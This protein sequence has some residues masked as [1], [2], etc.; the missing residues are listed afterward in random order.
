M[1]AAKEREEQGRRRINERRGEGQGKRKG[2]GGGEN[3]WEK[4]KGQQEKR[5]GEEKTE[6]QLTSGRVY[7]GPMTRVCQHCQALRFPSELFNC[8]HNGKV[9]LPPLGDYPS[10]LKD[11]FTGSNILQ[12]PGRHEAV[13]Q[14]LLLCFNYLWLHYTLGATVWL[15][16]ASN[17]K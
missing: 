8:C 9:S 14:C 10:P 2:R 13:Q 16:L 7:L 12:L 5:K 15:V 17:Y 4:K 6:Q 1:S 3:K 11:L